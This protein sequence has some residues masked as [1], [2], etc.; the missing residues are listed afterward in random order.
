MNKKVI[1]IGAGWYGC[2]L[3][4]LCENKKIDYVIFE[5]SS[6]IFTGASFYNQNRLHLGYHYPR[7]Y[8][9][10]TDSKNGFNSFIEQFP[11]LT[12]EISKNIYAIHKNSLV[13]F[14]TYINVFNFEKYN[15]EILNEKLS[16]N[17]QGAIVVNE[18]FIDPFKSKSFFQ[19]M[20]LNIKFNSDIQYQNGEYFLNKNKLIGDTII[21]ATYGGLE[22]E[23]STKAFKREIFLSFI[24]KMIN[25]CPFGALTVMDGAFYSIYPYDLEN[26]L[27]TLTHVKYGVISYHIK[28][29]EKHYLFNVVKEMICQDIPDFDKYFKF[30]GFFTSTK[31]K[32]ISNS[33]MRST[34][35]L[36]E[37]NSIVICSGK[38]DTIFLTNSIIN[39]L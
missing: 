38:I 24:I 16:E 30:E 11:Y 20:N 2:Y 28:E 36:K 25:P 19:K 27:Y 29:E 9:T 14:N 39:E 3:G 8:K 22:S 12:T 10:R 32:P 21:N 31:Y 6:E 7:D 37:Q 4:Y 18:R 5:K 26:N 35:L 33:D 1:I 17:F 34:I 23:I 13:D 15:F